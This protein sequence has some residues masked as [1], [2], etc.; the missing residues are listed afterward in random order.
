M[1]AF[2]SALIR[3]HYSFIVQ[4]SYQI[5]P[6]FLLHDSQL[7]EKLFG[8]GKMRKW[9]GESYSFIDE[10]IQQHASARIDSD[11]SNNSQDRD[12]IDAFLSEMENPNAHESFN[13]FQLQ[14]LCSE[15]FGNI[16]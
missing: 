2:Q 11:I 13:N 16:I 14:V 15:L 3:F 1:G 5:P 10:I 8:L 9:M 6:S 12:F 7:P 4:H